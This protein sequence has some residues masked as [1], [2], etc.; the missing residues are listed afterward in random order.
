MSI[1]N[2][3]IC[4][5]Y[6]LESDIKIYC[7]LLFQQNSLVM[8]KLRRYGSDTECTEEDTGIKCAP[9]EIFR[10]MTTNKRE[11]G[12]IGQITGKLAWQVNPE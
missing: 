8:T 11:F 9:I 3:I 1:K 7:L 4:I 12:Y 5:L 6:W 10:N 2:V